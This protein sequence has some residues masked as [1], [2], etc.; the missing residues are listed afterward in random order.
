M[1]NWFSAHTHSQFSSLDGMAEVPRLVTKAALMGYPA[2]GITD[3]GNMAATVQLY[4]SAMKAGI[5]PFP[6]VELYLVDPEFDGNLD[7]KG[8]GSVGRYH[9]CVLALNEKGYKGLVR[10]VST[11]HT[12]PRFSRFPRVTLADLVAFG[13]DY[14]DD[15][16]LLS[17]CFFGLTQQYLVNR[18]PKDAQRVLDMYRRSF[19]NTFVEIQNHNI[20]HSPDQDGAF[21]VT[22]DDDIVTELVTIADR[23]GL[24]VLATQD[25]HY[26]DQREKKAHALMKR[27]VYGGKEDEF[28]GDSFHLASSDWV[29]EH[30]D[31]SVW[32]RVEEASEHLLDLSKLSIKP[33]DKFKVHMPDVGL[34][35]PMKHIRMQCEAALEDYIELHA[36]ERKKAKYLKRLDYELDI[37]EQLKMA[38]YFVIWEDF[39]NWCRS[40]HICVEARGS[41]NGSL[42]LFLLKVTQIDPL[43]WDDLLFD[44][45]LSLDRI[46]PPDVD[47]DI[48]DKERGRAIAYLQSKYDTAQIGTWAKLGARQDDDKGSVLVSWIM[49]KRNECIAEGIEHGKL[50]DW[51]KYRSEEYGKTLF[52]DRYGDV[53]TL[54][55]VRK[56]SQTDYEGLRELAKMD[57][58]FRSYG[59]HA[60]GIL[61]SS[62]D[63]PI[64]DYVPTMLV[65]SSN[66]R[67]SQFHMDDVE[68]MGLLKLDVLG[69]VTLTTM[70]TCQALIGRQDPTDFSW[71][72]ED[73]ALACKLLRE[74]RV[75]NGIFHF[76]GYTKAKGG[77]EM[78]I[79]S[80]RDAILAQ[81]LY[82]PGAMDIAPGQTI[83]QKDLYLRRRKNVAE[84]KQVTYLHE[85]FRNALDGTY[86]TVI[87]QEQVINIMRGLGMSIEGVNKFFK[88]VK[89]SGKGAVERNRVR[90]LEVQEEFEE[91][92]LA[93]GIDEADLDEAWQLTAGFVAYGFN[94]AHASGYGL[95]AYRC[96]YLKAHH[97]LEFMTALLK[98][99]AGRDKEKVYQRE[100]RRIEI[101]L[102]P[103]AVNV[104][105]ES[106]GIDHERQAIRKG[107]LSIS[108]VGAAAARELEE[109]APFTSVVDI[110]E[111][112]DT[113][114]VTG[115]KKYLEEGTFSGTLAKLEAVGAL[116][117]VIEQERN[118]RATRMGKKRVIK[119]RTA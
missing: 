53:Q 79:R 80:V 73:D 90:M 32:A 60:G 108:G 85:A 81:G 12:R 116:D 16:A 67:A 17:G 33:L 4:Q 37:V 91:L 57:S 69:Q 59:V 54:Q 99:W 44:R 110:A 89:D 111:R 3:H 86:G 10:L 9:L 72:P 74:G 92:C 75:D 70:K 15:V 50:K 117:L 5:T 87:F 31:P 105:G 43:K 100:A 11:S 88:V 48:E 112:C 114:A 104:S 76:E 115:G 66:T 18:G 8:A 96:A 2:L 107:L 63:V 62:D 28:P 19:P 38:A 55:D 35:D 101:R 97:P 26:C 77:R 7:D 39:V 93:A 42:F 78:G 24:P 47:M 34:N 49:S 94:K 56:H 84:R 52:R 83:S 58:A 82:M 30:Y 46:K 36:L 103:P 20:V 51:P 61:L 41:A 109:K 29:G 64:D 71:I 45:F 119:K 13:R 14:G 21:K 98:S 6:G 102:L 22:D 27:M 40:E 95:R 68:A 25:S 65:A 106:W 1:S 113:R 23:L 118:D